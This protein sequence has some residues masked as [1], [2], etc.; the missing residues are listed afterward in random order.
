MNGL[1]W[2]AGAPRECACHAL[3]R[4][5]AQRKKEC[6]SSGLHTTSAEPPSDSAHGIK[7]ARTYGRRPTSPGASP[8]AAHSDPLQHN[9]RAAHGI[10]H[11]RTCGRRP[12][13]PGASPAA[14][15]SD[16]LQHNVR[17]ESAVSRPHHLRLSKGTVDGRNFAS[18]IDTL[19]PCVRVHPQPPLGP[20]TQCW[21]HLGGGWLVLEGG[22]RDGNFASADAHSR[23]P[24]LM[25]GGTGGRAR[26]A[27]EG[28]EL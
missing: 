11:A 27:R 23:L 24:T 16:P 10:K 17:A 4:R 8:A 25:S 13:S 21:P 7:H 1:H 18:K 12:T 20:L 6:A 26:C 14:A 22:F 9:V 15:Y 19:P 3:P 2:R 5:P 28:C